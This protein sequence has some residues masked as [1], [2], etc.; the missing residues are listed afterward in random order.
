MINDLTPSLNLPLPHPQNNL[1]DDVTRLRN[2]LIALD[3]AVAAKADQAE[4]NASLAALV[5]AA[6]ASMDSLRELAAAL[7]NDP[8]YAAHVAAT[9]TSIQTS[10]TSIQTTLSSTDTIVE[11]VTH[12]YFT[13]A[14]A[15]AAAPVQSVNGK[16][17]VSG[18]VTLG[19]ADLLL[20]NVDNTSDAN[21]PVSTAQAAAI[22]AVLGTLPT[23]L[24]PTNVTPAD[25]ATNISAPSF[26]GSAYY[27]L[28]GKAQASRQARMSLNS[29]FSTI[30]WDSGEVVGAST[31]V[32]GPSLDGLAPTSTLVYWQIR[33]KD[34]DGAWSSWSAATGFTTA[35]NYNNYIATPTATPAN[36]G[37]AFEG[38]FYTGIVWNQIAQAANSKLLATGSQVFTVPDMAGVPIVYAG[39]TLEVRSRANPANK[40]IGTVTGAKGTALTLN[41]TS[42]GGG[43]TFAD[44]SVMSRFRVIFAPKSSGDN[45]SIALKNANT[46]LPVACQTLTE[47]WAATVAM[48]AADTSTVYPA[49]YWARGL[50]IGG[51]TDWY[52]PARDELE[53]GWRNL[54]PTTDSNY[55][56]AD[57]STAAAYAYGNNGSYG[58]VA[59]THGTNNNSAPAGAA[60]TAGVPAQ[61]VAPAFRTGGAEAFTYGSSYYWSSSDFSASNAWS[62]N[63]YS[64]S[65]GYQNSGGKTAAYRVRA[66]RRSII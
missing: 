15:A 56:T 14:R 22:D 61:T 57:R 42:I 17:P 1:A 44:W 23:V 58:D 25:S 24:P 63:W 13:P 34:A 2:A 5:D 10:L 55:A 60:Y 65:P 33:Y 59:A 3:T 29:D 32:T 36:F 18:A 9:I 45:A 46:A 51:R 53:L 20:G 49:A 30:L 27:S 6:P 37:D 47:G 26:T 35:S 21:K 54:K 16:A 38:G 50:N 64:S 48:M 8:D 11:G 19:K 4:I 43:G 66:V 39:Q 7:G 40:F 28:Y 62:Q 31:A 12:L 52:I 41:V